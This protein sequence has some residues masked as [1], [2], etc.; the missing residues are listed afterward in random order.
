MVFGVENQSVVAENDALGVAFAA[1]IVDVALVVFAFF[2]FWE[3]TFVV[4]KLV[5]A[6]AFGERAVHAAGLVDARQTDVMGLDVVRNSR[7]R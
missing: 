1:A 5:A 6:D 4:A 3:L 7:F 2:L